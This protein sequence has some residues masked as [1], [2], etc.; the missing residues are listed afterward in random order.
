MN[1][2]A[3]STS[4][5]GYKVS[6]AT[7]T[8]IITGTTCSLDGPFAVIATTAVGV[9]TYI[10]TT[11]AAGNQSDY[12]VVATCISCGAGIAGD[13]TPTNHWAAVTPS[14]SPNPASALTGTAN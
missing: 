4:G 9:T 11:V 8:G 2:V 7:C 6:K 13:S 5:V 10:D 1:W 12:F 14:D 3:S